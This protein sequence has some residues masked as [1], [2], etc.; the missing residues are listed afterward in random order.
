MLLSIPCLWPW[1]GKDSFP[2]PVLLRTSWQ[3]IKTKGCAFPG[4]YLS[5][6]MVYVSKSWSLGALVLFLW[7][8]MLTFCSGNPLLRVKE[9]LSEWMLLIS[10][11]CAV[12][13]DLTVPGR[14]DTPICLN[15]HAPLQPPALLSAMPGFWT[16]AAHHWDLCNLCPSQW[17]PG[18]CGRPRSQF[19]CERL[20]AS[21]DCFGFPLCERFRANTFWA[22]NCF[23]KKLVDDLHL[24]LQWPHNWLEV[25]G[26]H[27]HHERTQI[28]VLK[29]HVI[30]EKIQQLC[31]QNI[32]T[33]N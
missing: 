8:F 28:Q 14:A 7:E 23:F 32:P 18:S 2:L 17:A 30:L 29:F 27:A 15:Q 21:L 10:L 19:S 4:S 22:S 20:M 1:P 12:E 6:R 11:L 9:S 33:Y 31:S 25:L 26:L 5:Q 16:S 3:N 13:R 24:I